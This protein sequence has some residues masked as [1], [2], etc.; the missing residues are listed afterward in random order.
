[1]PYCLSLKSG[2]RTAMIIG[3]VACVAIENSHATDYK[4]DFAA[5]NFSLTNAYSTESGFGIDLKSSVTLLPHGGITGTKPF[6]YSVMVPEGNY[7]VT[8]TFGDPSSATTNYVKAEARRLMLENVI[9]TKGQFI[10]RQFVV[11]TRTVS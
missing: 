8:V 1:M 6:F 10:S 3:C 2:L 7:R 4:F 11:N 5:R 9:T